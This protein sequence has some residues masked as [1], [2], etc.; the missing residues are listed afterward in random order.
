MGLLQSVLLC[1]GGM[2]ANYGDDDAILI[3]GGA[4]WV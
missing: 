1:L 2:V 3:Y 4:G